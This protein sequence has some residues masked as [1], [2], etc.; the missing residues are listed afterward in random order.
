M[1]GADCVRVPLEAI[2]LPVLVVGHA[3]DK[4]IRSPAELMDNVTARTNGWREQVVTV[5]GGPGMAGAPRIEACEGRAPHGFVD[6]EAEVAE[7]IARFIHGG[8]Y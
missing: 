5:T 8:N 3:A 7:G 6:Q 1:G 4:C 2:R